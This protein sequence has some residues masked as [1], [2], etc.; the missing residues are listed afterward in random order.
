MTS[1]SNLI[2]RGL[3]PRKWDSRP[4]TAGYVDGA[5]LV[6]RRKAFL[7]VGGFDEDFFFYAEEADLC[8]RMCK[9]GW[10]VK[11]FPDSLVTHIRGSASSKIDSSDRFV[12]YLIAARILLAEKHLP[13]WEVSVY[14]KSQIIRFATLVRAC[15]LLHA[16]SV[17]GESCSDKIN[18]FGVHERIWRERHQ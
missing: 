1:W 3:W 14:K 8:I 5:V 17:G 6:V 9:A 4:K 13:K 16:L 12:R 2:R 10:Q 18:S 15:R 11:F 7:D